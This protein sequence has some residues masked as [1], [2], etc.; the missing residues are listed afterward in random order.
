VSGSATTPNGVVMGGFRQDVTFIHGP[1]DSAVRAATL[2][3]LAVVVVDEGPLS[4][5]LAPPAGPRPI[6]GTFDLAV[7]LTRAHDFT[8]P[9]EV[10]FPCLPPGVEA[11]TSVVIPADK[12]EAVVTLVAHPTAEAGAW[13]IG[14]EAK[15]A[16]PARGRRDPLAAAAPMAAGGRRTRRTAVG[17]LPV[18][19]ELAPITVAEPFVKGQFL[20]V[21]GEQG[22]STTVVCRIGTSAPLPGP[23]T[24]RL[25]GLPPRASTKPVTLKPDAKQAEF[26]VAVEAT[27]PTGSHPSLVCELVGEIAGQKVV[28]RIGRG[29]VFSVN[30][31]GAVKT[32]AAGKPLSPLE[33]LRQNQ[34]S[35]TKNGSN[36]P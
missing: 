19:S 21:A 27:A 35:P 29:G 15:P 4:V 17:A 2:S 23:F 1:G 18:S 16:S 34:K 5:A 32:D 14:V 22:K 7:K 36:Q 3:K 9:V 13:R 10:S 20:P 28:Y 24:A 6:D 33:A 26:E 25:D 11:P 12:S 8:E 31:P 30:A